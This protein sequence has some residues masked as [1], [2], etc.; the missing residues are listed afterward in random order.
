MSLSSNVSLGALRL[1]AQQRADL[2]GSPNI[3]IPEWNQYLSLS[4]KE[5]M[6]ILIAAYGNDYSVQVPYLFTINSTSLYPLPADFYKLLG[7]DLQYAAS[8]SG[9]VT[10]KRFEFIERNKYSW[11]TPTPIS[12]NLCRLWYVPE[13]ASLQTLQ[14]CQTAAASISIT[15]TDSSDLSVGMNIY[16]N[17]ILPGTTLLTINTTTNVCTMSQAANSTQVN[18]ILALWNDAAYFDG[19]AGWEE[20]VII[21]AAIK[22]QIKQEGATMD[23]RT[24]KAEIKDRIIGMAEGRDAGQAH[25]VSDVLSVNN[26]IIS[27]GASNLAYRLSGSNIWFAPVTYDT[28][29]GDFGGF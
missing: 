24:Q 13:P 2:E 28:S 18:A 8:P 9:W 5:L 4:A 14:P 26:P 17:G 21:D 12:A 1:Q 25:H 20:Y 29:Q 6:D 27:L 15:V 11:L 16:G 3:S 7:V 19:I 22:A 23:L 10:L